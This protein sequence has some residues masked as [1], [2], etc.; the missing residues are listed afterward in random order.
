MNGVV[1]ASL[2][3]VI[4]GLLIE[5]YG[6]WLYKVKEDAEAADMAYYAGV[7]F[8]YIAALCLLLFL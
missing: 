5:F 7:M 8:I 6:Y 4:I 3:F 2:I 1:C